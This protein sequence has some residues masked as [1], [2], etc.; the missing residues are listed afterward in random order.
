MASLITIIVFFSGFDNIESIIKHFFN[1]DF[2]TEKQEYENNTHPNIDKPMNRNSENKLSN[3]KFNK[4]ND[5]PVSGNDRKDKKYS[6]LIEKLNNNLI[7]YYPFNGNANDESGNGN[8]GLVNGASLTTDRFGNTDNAYL[9]NGTSDYIQVQDSDELDLT[10]SFCISTWVK[11][12]SFQ[13]WIINK[14]AAGTN[15]D[16]SWEIIVSDPLKLAFDSSPFL[17]TM[18]FSNATLS[19]SAWNHIIFQY[20]KSNTTI[21]IYVNGNKDIAL[22]KELDI[23]NTN[24]SLIFGAEEATPFKNFFRG[25]L[26]DIR[27]YNCTLSKEEMNLLYHENG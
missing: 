21:E 20:D 17:S 5:I 8:N 26:D 14:H 3:P 11:P 2:P 15:N 13:G 23:R 25:S 9:F 16:G 19:Y 10:A 1:K 7:A 27:I 22:K 4:K 24:R 12:L 18:V 6:T